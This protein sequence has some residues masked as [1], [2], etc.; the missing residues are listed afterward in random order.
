MPAVRFGLWACLGGGLLVVVR[1]AVAFLGGCCGGG[2]G[3]GLFVWYVSGASS[4]SF[5]R[6]G[7]RLVCVL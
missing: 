6:V 4:G 2:S 1:A 5:W 7:S 3:A